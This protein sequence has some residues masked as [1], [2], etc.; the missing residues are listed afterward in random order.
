[1]LF[2][3]WQASAQ[4]CQLLF[5]EKGTIGLQFS[6]FPSRRVSGKNTVWPFQNKSTNILRKRIQCLCPVFLKNNFPNRQS[7]CSSLSIYLNYHTHFTNYAKMFQHE[8]LMQGAMLIS[9]KKTIIRIICLIL[10]VCWAIRRIKDKVKWYQGT[11]I[12]NI[13]DANPLNQ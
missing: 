7:S 12:S 1:M 8:Y 4:Q 2:N 9:S 3:I 10:C 6:I 13:Q 11:G 5:G